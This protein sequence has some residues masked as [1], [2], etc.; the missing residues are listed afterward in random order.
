M[1]DNY[2]D[3]MYLP[4]YRSKIRQAMPLRDRAAQFAPFAALT[5]YDAASSE[6]ARLTD[7]RIEPDDETV[8]IL[9]ERV[10]QLR[11]RISEKPEATVTFFVPDLRKA[12]GKYVT[13]HGRVRRVDEFE[14]TLVLTDGRKLPLA[15]VIEISMNQS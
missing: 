15:D 6:T 2:E 3:I 13:V 8:R 10:R 14:G 4:H 12:G 11:E 9:N 7:R 5:G 1:Q